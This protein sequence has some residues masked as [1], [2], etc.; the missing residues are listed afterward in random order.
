MDDSYT[1]LVLSPLFDDL[2]DAVYVFDDSGVLVDA[3]SRVGDVSGKGRDELVGWT[4]TDMVAQFASDEDGEAVVETV[5]QVR[6]GEPETARLE[7][8]LVSPIDG[9]VP[10]D[11]RFTRHE[12]YVV[13]VVRNLSEATRRERRLADLSE[14]LDVLNRVLRHDIY[15]DMNVVLGWADE[16]ADSVDD[17]A[18][19]SQVT[20]ITDAVTH[21]I[22]LT[23][24]ARD[25]TE[26]L[27]SGDDL[28][29]R[30]VALDRVLTEQLVKARR[31]FETATFDVTDEIPP[32]SVRANEMLSSVFGNVL[33]NAVVHSD[34]DEPTVTVTVTATDESTTVRVADDGP[35]ITDSAKSVVFGRGEAGLGSPGSG[36]GLYLVDQLVDGYGGSV[37]VEDNDPRGCVFVVELPLAF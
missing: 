5:E 26:S 28:P 16:L 8:S 9:V 35:G 13:V 7:F 15:N 6:E 12:E 4:L 25:L 36:I 27:T 18:A 21:T 11:G 19:R 33:G 3:N 34:R 37:R 20:H 10:V 24:A 32:V 17:P 2:Q 23:H 1:H 31:K 30:A 22:E 14:Q 29:L